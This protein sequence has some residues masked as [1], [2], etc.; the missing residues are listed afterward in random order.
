MYNW[1]F[2]IGDWGLRIGYLGLGNRLALV[3]IDLN[4]LEQARINC[5]RLEQAGIGLFQPFPAQSSLFSFISAFSSLFKPILV[6]SSIFQSIP[7]YSSQLELIPAY[8]S[9]FQPMPSYSIIYPNPQTSIPNTQC[10]ILHFIPDWP[11]MSVSSLISFLFLT[12]YAWGQFKD[13]EGRSST[14]SLN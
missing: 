14:T 10:Q 8:F 2:K 11:Y 5:N 9:L 13:S 3:E 7:T 1:A 12:E 6:N 4:R